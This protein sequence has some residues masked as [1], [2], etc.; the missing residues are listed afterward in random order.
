MFEFFIVDWKFLFLGLKLC[1]LQLQCVEVFLH[2]GPFIKNFVGLVNARLFTCPLIKYLVIDT[3]QC[4]LGPK[5]V[6]LG[7]FRQG[8]V[9]DLF[10]EVLVLTSHYLDFNFTLGF[11][12]IFDWKVFVGWG[13][14]F[15]RAFV[16]VLVF[17][18]VFNLS[19]SQHEALLEFWIL[20]SEFLYFLRIICREKLRLKF[21]ASE[22]S[23]I[24]LVLK[25]R[26]LLFK[27]V[28]KSN[29][30]FLFAN[31]G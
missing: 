21:S 6:N 17:D 3:S 11:F 22:L 10:Q 23:L 15:S 31:F 28:N 4:Q 18:L 20:R 25:F 2:L 16:F 19:F 27:A 13:F 8:S 24:K 14:Y 5:L 9:Q 29:K 12:S 1:K 7:L 30:S 26:G